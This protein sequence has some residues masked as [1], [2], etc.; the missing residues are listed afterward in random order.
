MVDADV[1]GTDETKGQT[2]HWLVNGVTVAGQ[3]FISIFITCIH[4]PQVAMLP[5]TML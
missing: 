1:V 5:W 4:L 3:V 2:R